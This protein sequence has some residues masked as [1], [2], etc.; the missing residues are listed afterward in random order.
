MVVFGVLVV[1]FV[2]VVWWT[3]PTRRRPLVRRWW[4]EPPS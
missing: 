3:S 4:R 2:G 1:L